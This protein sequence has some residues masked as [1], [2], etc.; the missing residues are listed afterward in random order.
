M[1]I[2][3]LVLI[4]LVYGCAGENSP[5]SS[6][7]SVDQ[8]SPSLAESDSAEVQRIY[9]QYDF[10]WSHWGDNK[11]QITSNDPGK[12]LFRVKDGVGLSLIESGRT[13]E[14][15]VLSNGEKFTVDF[16]EFDVVAGE[17]VAGHYWFDRTMTTAR[18]ELLIEELKIRYG[19]PV[20][21]TSS[22]ITW[23]KNGDTEV[24]IN[25]PSEHGGGCLHY[26]S[27][28]H[29][30]KTAEAKSYNKL[31]IRAVVPETGI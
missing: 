10:R 27:E 12:V 4:I 14:V 25:L 18:A 20:T 15:F 3:S 6:K 22:R 17:L 29:R 9:E 16:V 24:Y 21:T 31:P 5:V 30:A 28:E 19:E 26:Y 2:S 8:V 11:D 13:T 23:I 7:V 1:R